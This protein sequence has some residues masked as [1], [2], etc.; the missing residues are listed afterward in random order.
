MNYTISIV[1]LYAITIVTVLWL[2]YPLFK[3]EKHKIQIYNEI[4]P[5]P[6]IETHHWG[7]AWRPWW[8]RYGGVTK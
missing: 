1:I 3:Q 5:P 8:R 4:P 2:L 6:Q 7:Y